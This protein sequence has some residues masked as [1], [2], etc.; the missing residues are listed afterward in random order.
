MSRGMA[1]HFLFDAS[2]SLGRMKTRQMDLNFFVVPRAPAQRF[3]GPLAVLV[4]GHTGSTSEILAGGLQDLGRATIVGSTS[5]GMALPSVI[6]RMPN[7][8]AIQ[9]VMGDLVTSSGYRIEGQGI[10]PDI[11]VKLSP[12]SLALGGDPVIQAAMD[13][14]ES[15]H[16]QSTEQK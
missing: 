8:D 9:F 15:R 3:E 14:I 12:E 5:A 10:L 16:N 4:D 1:G 6:E 13:W 11:E 7:G 2:Q